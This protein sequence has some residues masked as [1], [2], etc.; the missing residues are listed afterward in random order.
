MKTDFSNR[1][2][3]RVQNS[4]DYHIQFVKEYFTLWKGDDGKAYLTYVDESS[5]RVKHC[6][7]EKA[8]RLIAN[9]IYEHTG[10]F[11]SSSNL[12]DLIG[13]LKQNKQLETSEFPVRRR[14]AQEPNRVLINTGW[15]DNCIISITSDHIKYLKSDEVDY[16]FIEI[17]SDK[18][19]VKPKEGDFYKAIKTLNIPKD[20]NQIGL[21]ISFMVAALLND[22]E[23]AILI[24]NGEQGSAK[25]S[26]TKFIKDIVDPSKNDINA[27]PSKLK[28]YI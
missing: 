24:L 7:I 6:L 9:A 13:Y 2:G 26:L 16:R 23:Y 12:D 19:Y 22:I 28:I 5:K 20:Q 1:A 17:D 15:D 3:H 18:P 21:I 11:P 4:T 25:S 10:R 27:F 8:N 14:I